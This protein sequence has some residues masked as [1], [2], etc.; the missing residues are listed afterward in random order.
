MPARLQ[1]T[2]ERVP[3]EQIPEF[4]IL[5]KHIK[6]FVPA[7]PFEI[8]GMD[9][10]LH[11]GNERAALETVSAKIPAAETGLRGTGLHDGGDGPGGDRL[12]TDAGQGA[13]PAAS[14]SAVRFAGTPDRR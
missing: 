3:L 12:A 4:E 13:R 5:A 10:A 14:A 8:G 1:N 9:A 11:A 2:A 7:R 6:T